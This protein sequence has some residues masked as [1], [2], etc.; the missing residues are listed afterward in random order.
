MSNIQLVEVNSPG[1]IGSLYRCPLC[2]IQT[3][4]YNQ[5]ASK[6]MDHL[7][8]NKHFGIAVKHHGWLICKCDDTTCES[9]GIINNNNNSE[10]V[11]KLKSHRHCPH[12][13]RLSSRRND[14]IFHIERCCPLATTSTSTSSTNTTGTTA[15][16][17]TMSQSTTIKKILQAR[18]QQ[19]QNSAKS[20]IIQQIEDNDDLLPSATQ[21]TATNSSSN[22]QTYIYVIN[23]PTDASSLQ[24]SGNNATYTTSK[25]KTPSDVGDLIELNDHEFNSKIRKNNFH[26]NDDKITI[27]YI[28][29]LSSTSSCSLNIPQSSSSG[30]GG[31]SGQIILKNHNL[32]HHGSSNHNSASTSGLSAHI[33]QNYSILAHEIT[34]PLDND[35]EL[36]SWQPKPLAY[37]QNKN[38]NQQR[39]QKDVATCQFCGRAMLKKNIPTHIRRAHTPKEE[40]VCINEEQNIFTLQHL[41]PGQRRKRSARAYDYSLM[42]ATISIDEDPSEGIENKFITE[43]EEILSTDLLQL[44]DRIKFGI[45]QIPTSTLTKLIDI[46]TKI[47]YSTTDEICSNAKTI[48]SMI[49]LYLTSSEEYKYKIKQI[50]DEI[51]EKKKQV[52]SLRA[53]LKEVMTRKAQLERRIQPVICDLQKLED[54][55]GGLI[56]SIMQL[57]GLIHLE[58]IHEDDQ[59]QQEDENE[60]ETDSQTITC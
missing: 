53:D 45:S 24:N 31:N 11:H 17:T 55:H 23:S 27:E 44:A 42:T 4:Y 50:G 19:Q 47:E 1:G 30:A 58:I 41:K 34:A 13:G 33:V 28:D 48:K 18:G 9:N 3:A 38:N 22:G 16:S 29:D 7:R 15:N 51:I 39:A 26:Q 46:L 60:D 12:C 10:G 25:R 21:N 37:Q 35:I 2:P 6:V 57:N 54:Q 36:K 49:V 59:H 56:D 40:L 20:N 14:F 43:G 5:V 32:D 8:G 52:S